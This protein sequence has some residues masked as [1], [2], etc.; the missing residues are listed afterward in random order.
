M[1]TTESILAT[2]LQKYPSSD[3]VYRLLKR[4]E[5][6]GEIHT[7]K[8]VQEG[9]PDIIKELLQEAAVEIEELRTLILKGSNYVYSNTEYIEP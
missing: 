1:Q 2:L 4:A 9:K 7:R 6:R 5:I 3:L 8:S